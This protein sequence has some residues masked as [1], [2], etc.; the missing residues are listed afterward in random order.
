MRRVY[1]CCGVE[2]GVIFIASVYGKQ[3]ERQMMGL[4]DGLKAGH[5]WFG[6]HA[7]WVELYLPPPKAM[8]NPNPWYFEM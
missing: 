2:V 6:G 8:F 1:I 3:R 4:P 7:L 5:E